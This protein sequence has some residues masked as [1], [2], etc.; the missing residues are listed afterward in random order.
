[1][2]M[3]PASCATPRS[4]H[5]SAATTSPSLFCAGPSPGCCRLIKRSPCASR[6]IRRRRRNE[7]SMRWTRARSASAPS[8]TRPRSSSGTSTFDSSRT[9]STGR[10]STSSV[11]W[12]ASSP[13]SRTCLGGSVS[14]HA[15]FF[16]DVGRGRIASRRYHY[17]KYLIDESDLDAETVARIER[18]FAADI[19]LYAKRIGRSVEVRDGNEA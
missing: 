4:T 3:R 14:G 12:S 15:Q 16:R 19:D 7:D 10:G 11:A 9:L 2:S 13:T 6:W 5:R 17:G 8:W 18:L 1:M